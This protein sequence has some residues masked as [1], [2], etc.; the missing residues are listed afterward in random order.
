MAEA[1]RRSGDR[2]SH[3]RPSHSPITENYFEGREV[4]SRKTDREQITV[5]KLGRIRLN[6]QSR[7]VASLRPNSVVPF[8]EIGWVPKVKSNSIGWE[9]IMRT[10]FMMKKRTI[11]VS[12]ALL[13]AA[14]CILI[15]LSLPV[16]AQTTFG[17]ISAIAYDL[18]SGGWGWSTG[19]LFEQDAKADALRRCQ[20]R[21]GNTH[22]KVVIVFN[23]CG[24]LTTGSNG[25]YWGVGLTKNLAN[26]RAMNSCGKDA[27]RNCKV[28]ISFCSEEGT[29]APPPVLDPHPSPTPSPTPTPTPQRP[30]CPYGTQP[31]LGGCYPY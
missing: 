2:R 12:M 11:F 4:V 31:G 18:T 22:C 28:L 6:S 27:S 19:W 7:F 25:A 17:Y 20:S 14:G 26:S 15:A 29:I 23:S 24:A 13:G 5:E 21:P 10:T 16:L 9:A 1:V 30:P 8:V 3:R